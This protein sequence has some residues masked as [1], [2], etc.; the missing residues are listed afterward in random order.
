MTADFY[1][2][3][4][5]RWFVNATV[6]L[7]GMLFFLDAN[8]VPVAVPWMMASFGV[9]IDKI[10]WVVNA[11]MIAVAV[12]MPTLGWLGSRLGYK[13]LFIS[14]L[15][16]YIVGGLLCAVSTDVDFVIGFRILQGFGAAALTTVP[17]AFIFEHFSLPERGMAIGFYSLGSCL[18]AALTPALS[19]YVTEHLGWPWVFYTVTP[20]GLLCL[21]MSFLLLKEI[22]A[23][24]EEPFDFKGFLAMS[25][26]L[27]CLLIALSRGQRWGWR[28]D[29]ILSLFAISTTFLILFLWWEWKSASPLVQ[30]SLYKSPTFLISSL[31]SLAFG[32]GFFGTNFLLPLFI[33]DLA[34]YSPIQYGWMMAPGIV[35]LGTV[36]YLAGKM[37]D[38]MDA[39]IPLLLGLLSFIAAFYWLSRL[40]IYSSALA[41]I[42]MVVMRSVG[43]SFIYPPLMYVSL[44]SVPPTSV[45]L[46][47]GLINVIRQLGGS[48]GIA[49][50]STLLERREIFHRAVYGEALNPSSPG[51]QKFLSGLKSSI[52]FQAG[53]SPDQVKDQALALIIQESK[54]QALIAAFNDCFYLTLFIF[55]A[56][57]LPT[58]FISGRRRPGDIPGRGVESSRTLIF[59]QD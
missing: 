12:A 14:A 52:L 23:G 46:A 21:L 48:F 20:I 18:P 36:S 44:N 56:C 11:Y 27:V 26:F 59:P 22:K 1:T 32:V 5:Y 35:V 37:S 16:F 39:R 55:L 33:E 19:G 51:L 29:Y 7:G 43:M 28:S 38:Q 15:L 40:D 25:G 13:T 34:G 3:P 47:A 58:L 6:T 53:G 8:T 24:N 4:S 41:I 17:L 57:F 45:G 2:K 10:Q 42:G 49:A 9:D 50:L 54:R 30:L 31:I